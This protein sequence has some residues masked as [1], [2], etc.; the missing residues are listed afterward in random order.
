VDYKTGSHKPDKIRKPSTRK[1]EGGAYWRQL[2]FYQ[3]LLENRSTEQQR[4]R[5]SVIVYLDLNARGELQQ[6]KLQLSAQELQQAQALLR[7]SYQRI[8]AHDFYEGCGKPNCEWCAF[9]KESVSPPMH[10]E[11]EV[12]ELD[13]H[14]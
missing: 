12:E 10:T 5:E 1:P 9:A 13:D 11:E 8:L 7:D 4:V 3:L 6:E 2:A 14:S